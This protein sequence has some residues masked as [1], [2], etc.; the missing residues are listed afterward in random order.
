[1][2]LPRPFTQLSGEWKGV[3]R[4]YLDG[5]SGPEISSP[6]RMTIAKVAR[7]TL[8]MLA[9]TWKYEG[10]PHEG[11]MLLCHDEKANVATAAWGDSWHMNARLMQCTGAIEP[12]N[13]FSVRGSYAAPPG[14]D[15]GWEMVVSVGDPNAIEIVM[16]NISPKGERF[17]AVRADFARLGKR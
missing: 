1:M 10:L 12:E 17:L 14:P 16:Q 11:V 13:N 15:W 9:Y 5:E 2:P 3:K 6:S 4:L 8:L 7:G